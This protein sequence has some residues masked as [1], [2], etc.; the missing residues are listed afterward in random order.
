MTVSYFHFHDCDSPPV[1]CIAH[2]IE[3]DPVL[4]SS[5]AKKKKKTGGGGGGD[6]NNNDLLLDD[7][8]AFLDAEIER[9]QN[10][11]G[12]EV[13]GSGPGYR[14]IV[15]GILN[16]RPA[17]RPKPVNTNAVSSLRTKLKQ[18]QNDRKVKQTPKKK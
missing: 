8:M 9:S 12:R 2:T 5:N 17:P 14:T 15:N 13:F 11:H 1:V 3:M 6:S 4:S 7:D 16:S 18:A 10:E